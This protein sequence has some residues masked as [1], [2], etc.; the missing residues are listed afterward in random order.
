MT[1]IIKV[2]DLKEG[3]TFDFTFNGNP[4]IVIN[5]KGSFY[6]YKNVCPH[7]GGQSRLEGDRLVCQLHFSE[8]NPKTGETTAGPADPGTR[9]DRIPIK[10]EGDQI[11]T[12]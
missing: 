7:Q 4:A 11:I 2:A 6:A 10:I 9:L 5:Y 12:G 3:D 8:F 1:T